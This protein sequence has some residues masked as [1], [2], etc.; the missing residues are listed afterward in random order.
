MLT[1]KFISIKTMLSNQMLYRF[2]TPILF[3]NFI[4]CGDGSNPTDSKNTEKHYEIIIQEI[5]KNLEG[6]V[7]IDS[8]SWV[9]LLPVILPNNMIE[10]SGVFSA[11]I[12]NRSNK[13]IWLRYDLRFFDDDGFLVDDFIPFGQPVIIDPN[14]ELVI[15]GE[16]VVRSANMDQ[17]MR[18][19]IMQFAARIR[20]PD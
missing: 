17:A 10:I 1:E 14:S 3:L 5:N 19:T 18:M 2:L 4:T 16:F 15:N 7:K 13:I 8:V 9:P 20:L 6:S 12:I 11:K